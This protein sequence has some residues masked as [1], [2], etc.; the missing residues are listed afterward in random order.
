MPSKTKLVKVRYD[1]NHVRLNKGESMRKGGGYCY[2]W[3][4]PDKKRHS[5][6]ASTLESLRWKESQIEEDRSLGLREDQSTTTINEVFELWKATKRGIR[7]RTRTNY[8]YFYELFVMPIFGTKRIQKVKRTDVKAFYNSLVEERGLKLSTLDNVHTVLHQVFQLAVDDYIIRSNPSDRILTEIKRAVGPDTEP[9]KALTLEQETLF[10]KNV[11]SRPDFQK[12]FPI[13]YIM[14]NTGMRV[15]EITGLRWCDVDFEK[16]YISVNHTLVYYNHRDEEGC[17]YTIHSPK[18][19]KSIR[20]IPLTPSVRAAF[21]MQKEYLKLA[22]LE[23]LDHICGYDDFIFVNRF[24]HVFNQSA[25]NTAIQRMVKKINLE[26]LDNIDEKDDPV[27]IPFFSCHVLRHT[28]ATKMIYF[29]MNV[30]ALQDILGH[31]EFSTT[32]D[33]YVDRSQTLMREELEKIEQLNMMDA[34]Y[35]AFD[36]KDFKP[37]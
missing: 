24:G 35:F 19:K 34:N 5:V 28:F 4:T 17:Y 15:G 8:I 6:Y 16:N 30:K 3:S 32:M 20:N 13:L 26:I 29:G 27:L 22:E 7:D 37:E 11:Y 2:R 23:C 14:A 9:R 18:T 10:F 33:I 21:M 12:W 36:F 31:Q 25:I 1:D